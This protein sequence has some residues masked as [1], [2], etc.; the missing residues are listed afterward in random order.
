MTWNFN[1]P[2]YDGLYQGTHIV[3]GNAGVTTC[4][5]YPYST[6][7]IG[8]KTV[9]HWFTTYSPIEE[10]TVVCDNVIPSPCLNSGITPVSD[11]AKQMLG[12]C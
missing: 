6:V 5:R 3:Y 1:E 8:W 12:H 10:G 9:T 11:V 7:P 4:L 2:G